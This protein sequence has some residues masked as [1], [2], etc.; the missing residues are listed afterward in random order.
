MEQGSRSRLSEVFAN[1]V[2]CMKGSVIQS[3]LIMYQ[4][5]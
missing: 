3:V 4:V 1:C 2:R 5:C